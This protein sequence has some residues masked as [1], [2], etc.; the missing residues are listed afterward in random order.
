MRWCRSF[1]SVVPDVEDVLDDD[2]QRGQGAQCHADVRHDGIGDDV[3][4]E[5]TASRAT[6]ADA[7]VAEGIV[8]VGVHGLLES[9]K[10]CSVVATASS[11]RPIDCQNK[12]SGCD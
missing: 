6:D 7:E 12:T 8:E 5:E 2:R 1:V 3:G 9:L 4:N 11:R 10:I